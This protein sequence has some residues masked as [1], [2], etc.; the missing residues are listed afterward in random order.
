VIVSHEHRFIFIKS[1]KTAGTSLE[2]ALS[3]VCGEDDVITP[4][5]SA[6]EAE[7]AA[8]GGLSPRNTDVSLLHHRP[9]DWL[10]A[11]RGKGR[12]AFW[13][14]VD[15]EEVRAWVGR[16]IWRDYYK[17]SIERNPWDRA[18]SLYYWRLRDQPSRPS[19]AE[20]FNSATQR[21]ISNL[22]FY[23]IKGDIVLD[24]V[25]RYEKLTD[26]LETLAG[27]LGLD[28]SLQLPRAKSDTR[29]DRRPYSE[30]LGA[31]ERDIIARRCAREIELLGYEF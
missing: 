3:R 14:H 19:M 7:R 10:L 26:E 17:F 8:I 29:K 27:T 11:L 9:T 21:A 23:A 24:H 25:L 16:S 28:S 22:Q 6:H 20:F 13:E 18:I 1:Q 31:E 5:H 4:L 2:L 30:V 15:A 12:R